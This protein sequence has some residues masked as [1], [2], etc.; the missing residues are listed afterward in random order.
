MEENVAEAKKNQG[1]KT[2]CIGCMVIVLI[3]IVVFVLISLDNKNEPKSTSTKSA[4]QERI[5]NQFSSWDGSHFKLTRRI[6]KSMHNPKSYKH[7]KTAWVE[8]RDYIN[9]VTQ[10]QGENL[11]GVTVTN[12]IIERVNLNG[13]ILEIVDGSG[14]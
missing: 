5:E 4:R 14:L 6:K 10:Y 8:H 1:M 12:S 3:P 9:V 7:V 11:F 2:G 13:E